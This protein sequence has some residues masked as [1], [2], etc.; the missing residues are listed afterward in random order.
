MQSKSN[1]IPPA[2]SGYIPSRGTHGPPEFNRP[3]PGRPIP[4]PALLADT[5][6][7][8]HGPPPGGVVNQRRG[9]MVVNIPGAGCMG[10]GGWCRGYPMGRVDI[11]SCQGAGSCAGGP[12]PWG[13]G[14]CR[15]PGPPGRSRLGGAYPRFRGRFRGGVTPPGDSNYSGPLYTNQIEL[16]TPKYGQKMR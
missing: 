9:R 1:A 13:R 16:K 3:R 2:P 14:F 12:P 8:I 15:L 10:P 4:A 11:S 7:P 6:P 5:P